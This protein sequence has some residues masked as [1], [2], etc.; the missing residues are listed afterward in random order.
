M[1][2]GE[3]LLS[4]IASVLGDDLAS[5]LRLTW[6]PP[7][8]LRRRRVFSGPVAAAI[9]VAFLESGTMSAVGVGYRS[10]YGSVLSSCSA[11]SRCCCSVL[12]DVGCGSGV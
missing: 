5:Y 3:A 2:I 7:W 1:A 12:F 4:S 8:L 6:L 9:G 11:V 10:G